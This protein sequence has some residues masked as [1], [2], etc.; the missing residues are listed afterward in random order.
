MMPRMVNTLRKVTRL[1]APWVSSSLVALTIAACGDS[2]PAGGDSTSTSTSTSTGGN[3]APTCTGYDE[4]AA[5][6]SPV[7]RVTNTRQEPVYFSRCFPRFSIP[8]EDELQPGE[9]N[10]WSMITCEESLATGKGPCCGCENAQQRID[11]GA[12][13]ELPWTGRSYHTAK[14]P[15][16]CYAAGV[17]P[18]EC[19]QGTALPA[20]PVDIVVHLY[21]GGNPGP[22]YTGQPPTEPFDVQRTFQL[23]TDATFDV[24]VE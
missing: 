14:M 12:T 21:A 15:D 13:A 7:I 10:D 19:Y 4:P 3:P 17:E 5:V 20:G 24:T 2:E 11:P 1:L 23:G 6:G 18:F 8:V 9:L 22:G 16:G